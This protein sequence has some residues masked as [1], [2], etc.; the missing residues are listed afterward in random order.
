MVERFEVVPD[1]REDR[2]FEISECIVDPCL[3]FRRECRKLSSDDG[4]A[5]PTVSSAELP[6]VEAEDFRDRLD[7]LYSLDL[8][9]FLDFECLWR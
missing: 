4:S 5:E 1:S 2:V 7:L 8:D 6:A 9:L 3:L